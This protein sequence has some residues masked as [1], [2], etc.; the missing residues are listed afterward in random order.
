MKLGEKCKPSVSIWLFFVFEELESALETSNIKNDNKKYMKKAK[1]DL[2]CEEINF[3][4]IF[5][6]GDF[7]L[8]KTTEHIFSK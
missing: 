1:V 3:K 8:Q 7:S 6:K 2:L 5:S 4:L